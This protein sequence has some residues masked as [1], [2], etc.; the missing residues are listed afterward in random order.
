M[1]TI[2]KKT[3][4]DI[5]FKPYKIPS[6]LTSSIEKKRRKGRKRKK[7]KRRKRKEKKRRRRKRQTNRKS[8]IKGNVSL[9]HH[10]Y[11]LVKEKGKVS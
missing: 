9:F 11:K 5:I 8:I 1:E 10:S 6:E 2:S 7:K 3:E 4:S